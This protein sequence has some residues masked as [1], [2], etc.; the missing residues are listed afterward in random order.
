MEYKTLS[1]REDILPEF[2]EMQTTD[3]KVKNPE[4]NAE[5]NKYIYSR[6]LTFF[7]SYFLSITLNN[8]HRYNNRKNRQ[9]TGGLLL[10][11]LIQKTWGHERGVCFWFL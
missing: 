1:G 4:K 10:A 5:N 6:G 11:L 8:I 9:K 3:I 2:S 7:Y